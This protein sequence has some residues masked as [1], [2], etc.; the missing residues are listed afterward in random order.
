MNKN[1]IAG[2]KESRPVGRAGTPALMCWARTRGH[3]SVRDDLHERCGLVPHT[4]DL[5]RKLAAEGFVVLAPDLFHDHPDV[6][7]LN[8]GDIM[9]HPSD[10]D[11][12]SRCEDVFRLFAGHRRRL[13]ALRH[14]RRIGTGATARVGG[15]ADESGG[16]A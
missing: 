9:F 3:L 7:G 14:D 1:A 5:A 15:A 13:G 2:V 10:A 6:A 11:V 12:Q 4:E 8:A 16:P